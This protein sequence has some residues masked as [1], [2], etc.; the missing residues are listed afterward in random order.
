[1]KTKKVICILFLYTS[2]VILTSCQQ[3][4]PQV[5]FGEKYSSDNSVEWVTLTD[6]VDLTGMNL[7]W[8]YDWGHII[9]NTPFATDDNVKISIYTD[10]YKDDN[11]EFLY[12]DGHYWM[13]L[14]ETSLG[15]YPLFPRKRIQLGGISCAVFFSEENALH[16]LITE[17]WGA[18]YQIYDCI[19]D[20]ERTEIRILS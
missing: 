5:S 12:N 20:N 1:M 2:F 13:L 10:A 18:S 19:F 17:Q 7:F 3:K 11:G 14:M 8:Q 16:V 15:D 9:P 6:T 4:S